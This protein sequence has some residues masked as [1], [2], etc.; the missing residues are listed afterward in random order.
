VLKLSSTYAAKHFPESSDIRH[1]FPKRYDCGFLSLVDAGG[2]QGLCVVVVPIHPSLM[3]K[4]W[5]DEPMA[6]IMGYGGEWVRDENSTRAEGSRFREEHRDA[7]AV[8]AGDGYRIVFTDKLRNRIIAEQAKGIES[9][10][11]RL[12]LEGGGFAQHSTQPNCVAVEEGGVV[13]LK[14]KRIIFFGQCITIF[15]GQRCLGWLREV[16]GKRLDSM[17]WNSVMPM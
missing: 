7:R 16:C 17:G 2:G 11:A 6:P 5:V 15:Y 1:R 8:E 9:L 10:H 4:I 3:G 14:A 12:L 13:V